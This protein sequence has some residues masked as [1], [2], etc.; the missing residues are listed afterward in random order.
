MTAADMTAALD[1]VQARLAG[2]Q[3]TAEF[4]HGIDSRDLDRAMATWHPEGVLSFTPGPVLDGSSAIRAF[5][6]ETLAAYAELHHWITNLSLTLRGEGDMRGECRIA[7]LGVKHSGTTSREA[8]TAVLDYTKAE[9]TWLIS[10]QTVIIRPATG[11]A[12]DHG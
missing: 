8:G 12:H 3:L 1:E 10:R 7:F 5:L 11:P 2:A 9:G 4:Y 6:E